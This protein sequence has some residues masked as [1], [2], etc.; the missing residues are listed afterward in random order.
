MIK[1]VINNPIVGLHRAGEGR[2]KYFLG[3]PKA[4]FSMLTKCFSVSGQYSYGSEVTGGFLGSQVAASWTGLGRS[5]REVLV[6]GLAGQGMVSMPVC[7][8]QEEDQEEV[9]DVELLCL[10]WTQLAAF[11]PSLR[12]WYS[13]SDNARLPYRLKT[14]QYQEYIQWALERRYQ[15]LPYMMTLQQD[16]TTTGLPLVRPM[17]LHYSES[18]MF[19]LWAQFMLGP[20]LVVAAVT[21]PRQEVV[22]VRLPPGTWYDW[23]SGIKYQSPHS[24]AVLPVQA[25]PYELPAFQRGGSVLIVYRAL[26]G[27]EG[28]SGQNYLAAA[29]LE[30]KV[31][32]ECSGGP[33]HLET[34]QAATSQPWAVDTGE[35]RINV[36]V[37]TQAGRGVVLLHSEGQS[38]RMLDIIFI[39]GLY[40]SLGLTFTLETEG[41]PPLVAGECLEAE[42]SVCWSHTQDVVLVR[43]IN[44]TITEVNSIGWDADSSTSSTT[45]PST[46]TTTTTITTTTTV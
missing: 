1:F 10:R 22:E 42:S 39:S 19:G 15:L 7:G 29:S 46:T 16:W 4:L 2:L 17:F 36:T 31:A 11:M 35:V 12:S 32:L 30:L 5:L 24:A 8:T 40:P 25:R 41:G 27:S 18:F 33:R 21:S 34:C 23:Y 38:G 6:L 28:Q 43:N 13:G 20:D 14:L 37:N 9:E 3:V 26:G 45:S 44:S